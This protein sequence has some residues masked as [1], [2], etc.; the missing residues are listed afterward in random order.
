[1][2]ILPHF[3]IGYYK[4][5][6]HIIKTKKIKNIIH[7]SKDEPFIKKNDIEQ[8]R[9]PIDYDEN[10]SLE[11]QNNIMYQHLYDITDYIHEKIINNSNILLIGYINKQD[12]DTIVISYFIKFGKLTIRESIL[13]YKSK[14]EHIFNPKCSFYHALNKFYN[15]NLN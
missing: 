10:Q 8:I 2:E 11:V 9:V 13:F 7:L 3:W 12:I 1:M 14:K 4:E 5:N 6:L 15:N